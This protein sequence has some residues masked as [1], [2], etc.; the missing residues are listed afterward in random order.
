M[1]ACIMLKKTL[2]WYLVKL[3]CCKFC[4]IVN[5]LSCLTHYTC[6]IWALQTLVWQVFPNKK[7]FT[8]RYCAW[9]VEYWLGLIIYTSLYIHFKSFHPYYRKKIIKSS[10]WFF[11]W[12]R[13]QYLIQKQMYL[14]MA[15]MTPFLSKGH[16]QQNFSHP[17]FMAYRWLILSHVCP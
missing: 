8:V 15:T 4:F 1:I 2:S 11:E 12:N 14:K 3:Y 16:A 9:V 5:W 7:F 10:H 17:D 6:L 13:I